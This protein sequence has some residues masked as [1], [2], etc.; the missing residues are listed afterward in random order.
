MKEACLGYPGAA[1]MADRRSAAG[2]V[3]TPHGRRLTA[4]GRD[5]TRH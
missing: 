3:V 4:G 1:L 2:T 5:R